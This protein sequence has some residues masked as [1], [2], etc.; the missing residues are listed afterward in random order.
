[1]AQLDLSDV[2]VDGEEKGGKQNGKTALKVSSA[3]FKPDKD[4][5]RRST[6]S[7]RA[8]RS[9]PTENFLI[10]RLPFAGWDMIPLGRCEG[11]ERAERMVDW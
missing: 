6:A 1:M 9:I 10:A 3:F 7:Y 8:F 11:K 2:K 4:N 5:D